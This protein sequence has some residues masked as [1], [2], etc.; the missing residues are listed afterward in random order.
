MWVL[1]QTKTVARNEAYTRAFMVRF[2]AIP[3]SCKKQNTVTVGLAQVNEKKAELLP[4]LLLQWS[5]RL[6][7]CNPKT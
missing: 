4:Q 2:K 6:P 5:K 7:G 3:T 1:M